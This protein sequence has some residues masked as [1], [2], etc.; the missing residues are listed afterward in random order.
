MYACLHTCMTQCH[1][2]SFVDVVT[3][4]RPISMSPTNEMLSNNREWTIVYDQPVSYHDL[5]VLLYKHCYV[6]C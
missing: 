4:P 3:P 2:S 1:E 5:H 6:S